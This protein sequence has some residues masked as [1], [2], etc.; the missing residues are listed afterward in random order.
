M[1]C[2][3]VQNCTVSTICESK[4]L[5]VVSSVEIAE[6]SVMILGATIDL[7][8]NL[9]LLWIHTFQFDTESGLLLLWL[10]SGLIE[11]KRK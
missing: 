4:V 9:S 7:N 3:C 8:Q 2:M 10:P 5:K 6:E 1:P 11:F